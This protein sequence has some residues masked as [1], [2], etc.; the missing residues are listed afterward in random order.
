M[1]NSILQASFTSGE[2]SPSMYGRLDFGKYYTGLKTCRNFIIRQFGGASNRPGT[3]FV[4]EVSDS[5]NITRLIPFE[6]SSTQ[7]YVLEFGHLVL[8]IIKDGGVVVW[9]SGPSAG[10]PVEVVTI[11]PSTA[12]AG[13]KY[14]Q[15]ADVMTL[16]HPDYPTQQLS[17]TDHHLWN[18]AAFDNVGGPFQE[19]NIDTTK[20]LH[21]TAVTGN[22]TIHASDAIFLSDMVGQMLYVEQSADAQIRRWEVAVPV[23]INDFK[24]AESNYYQALTTG[25]TGTRKPD[26]VEGAD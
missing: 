24:R 17:R 5:E 20:T 2:L 9:P 10:Q 14:T 8:R 1:G 19:L 11:W 18:L 12:L 13:L 7:A 15:S 6:F 22:V 25:T 21:A 26:H 4:S 23:T 16:C 3:R